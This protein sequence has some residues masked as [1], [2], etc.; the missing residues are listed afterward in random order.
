[1]IPS[2][3]AFKFRYDTDR[4]DKQVALCVGLRGDSMVWVFENGTVEREVIRD[5]VSRQKGQITEVVKPLGQYFK[6][7]DP[8][9]WAPSL[10]AG[11]SKPMPPAVFAFVLM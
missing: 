4:T 2:Y 11:I 6:A 7:V 1:L 10:Q 8:F 5:S 9:S 3:R